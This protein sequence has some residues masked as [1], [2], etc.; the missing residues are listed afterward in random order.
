MVKTKQSYICNN[1]NYIAIKW[2]GR[3]PECNEWNTLAISI[4]QPSIATVFKKSEQQHTTVA[5]T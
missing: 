3:C 2:L 1:C 5:T 4:E